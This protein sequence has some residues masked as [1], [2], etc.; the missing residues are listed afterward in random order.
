M[1]N[2]LIS[3]ILLTYNGD[4]T[5]E[6]A[7]RSVLSQT[8]VSMEV[9][10][11]DDG[12][13]DKTRDMLMRFCPST[14]LWLFFR[15]HEGIMPQSRFA[16]RR[17]TG[18]YIAWIGQDDVWTA[19]NKLAV[20]VAALEADPP[21]MLCFTDAENVVP[22]VPD[23]ITYDSLLR[24]NYICASTV[25][26]R[27]LGFSAESFMRYLS[28]DDYPIELCLSRLGE[29]IYLPDVTTSYGVSDTS[30][31]RTLSRRRRLHWLG[32]VYRVK[33]WFISRYGCH[34]STA[35]YVLW[36]L[37]RDMVSLITGRWHA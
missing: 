30:A 6:T 17:A 10:V 37:I 3:V 36:R 31:S 22:R 5:I 13:T 18:R 8:G 25:V 23:K 9:I 12:S 11:V 19:R 21:A 27:N 1:T 16:L 15:D 2:P 4:R 29:F 14:T 7:L 32:R 24:G 28:I 35:A 33:W 20:Q 34:P 26:F